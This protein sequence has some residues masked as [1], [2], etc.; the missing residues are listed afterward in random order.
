MHPFKNAASQRYDNGYPQ[1][2]YSDS[3]KKHKNNH[4]QNNYQNN[5][6]NSRKK[7]FTTS[8]Y[9]YGKSAAIEFSCDETKKQRINTITLHAAS[10]RV[11]EER[12]YD[13]ENKT[14]VQLPRH[15]LLLAASILLGLRQKGEFKQSGLHSTKSYSIEHQGGKIFFMVMERGK[16]IRAVGLTPEDCYQVTSLFLKQLKQNAPWMSVNEIVQ[17]IE[18]TVVRMRASEVTTEAGS[19][20]VDESEEDDDG[21]DDSEGQAE[22]LIAQDFEAEA[23]VEEAEPNFNV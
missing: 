22:F 20:I 17:L 1:K 21:D 14:V 9:A 18:L 23:P 8:Y 12:G 2:Q 19:A 15:E 16:P 13:W 3:P 10:A 5:H 4:S 6:R 7:D 11:S